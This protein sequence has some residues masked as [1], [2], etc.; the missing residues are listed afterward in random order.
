MST[1]EV[2]FGFRE[3]NPDRPNRPPRPTCSRKAKVDAATCDLR[4]C[5]LGCRLGRRTGGLAGHQR[6]PSFDAVF[7]HCRS[8]KDGAAVRRAASG[9]AALWRAKVPA[10]TDG[11]PASRRS[12]SHEPPSLDPRVLTDCFRRGHTDA[13]E[14][15]NSRASQELPPQTAPKRTTRWR[16]LCA[17]S[18]SAAGTGRAA[19]R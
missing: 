18:R 8:R 4:A 5:V 13:P 12:R 16:R 15:G 9:R 6:P 19:P 10:R 1:R 17:A 11:D 2:R 7:A 14:V 3:S